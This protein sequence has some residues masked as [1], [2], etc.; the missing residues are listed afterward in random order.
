M[1][2]WRSLDPDLGPGCKKNRFVFV[3]STVT[4]E[5][6]FIQFWTG[7]QVQNLLAL[8]IALL[9]WPAAQLAQGHIMW[10]PSVAL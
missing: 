6:V 4:D 8:P 10:L 3:R 1:L 5:Y 7:V 2:L 9:F